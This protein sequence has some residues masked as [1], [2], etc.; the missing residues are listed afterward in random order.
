MGQRHQVFLIARVVPHNATQA[1]HRCIAALHHQWCYGDLPLLATRRLL[2]LI[3]QKDNAE[4]IRAE[5]Q[6]INGKYGG[7][8]EEPKIP[9]IPCSCTALLLA[10]SWAIDLDQVDVYATDGSFVSADVGSGD[11]GEIAYIAVRVSFSH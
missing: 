9:P 5:I 7:S 6:N 11:V 2:T 8:K 1:K 3:K 4:I 10:T